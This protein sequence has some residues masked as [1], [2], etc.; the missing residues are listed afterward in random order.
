MTRAGLVEIVMNIIAGI[1]IMAI[2][3]AGIAIV[4][5]LLGP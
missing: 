3:L 2:I 5:T 1:S 4:F